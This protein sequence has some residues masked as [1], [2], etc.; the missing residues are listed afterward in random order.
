MATESTTKKKSRFRTILKVVGCLALYGLLWV[1]IDASVFMQVQTTNRIPTYASEYASEMGLD[2]HS[3]YPIYLEDHIDANVKT[4]YFVL[5]SSLDEHSKHDKPMKLTFVS[6]TKQTEMQVQVYVKMYHKNIPHSTI[7]FDFDDHGI[8]LDYRFR[9]VEWCQKPWYPGC[10]T[11][12][13]DNSTARDAPNWDEVREQGF[14]ELLSWP[15]LNGVT[16]NL[17]EE[18]YLLY[19]D[20]ST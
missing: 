17:S 3:I 8:P 1:G 2:V 13:E 15:Y 6:G 9:P 5:K 20:A 10:H 18:D 14:S 7:S 19:W 4:D 12:P 11:F 16:I